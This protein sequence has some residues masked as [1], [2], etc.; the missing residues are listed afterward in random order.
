MRKAE[1]WNDVSYNNLNSFDQKHADT[2]KRDLTTEIFDSMNLNIKQI[3]KER[4]NNLRNPE[5]NGFGTDDV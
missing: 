4:P 1:N 3:L 2:G 5:N